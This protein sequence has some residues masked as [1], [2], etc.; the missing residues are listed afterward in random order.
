M[1]RPYFYFIA[2]AGTV[3]LTIGAF[4]LAI[5]LLNLALEDAFAGNEGSTTTVIATTPSP[6]QKHIATVY[7][8]MG[9]GA[10]GW[11]SMKVNVRKSEEQ[12]SSPGDVF[13]ASC[14]TEVQAQWESN[15]TLRI[16]YSSHDDIVSSHQERLSADKIVRVLY[17]GK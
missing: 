14:G 17:L 13:S 16:L 7:S 8:N 1:R 3:V 12:F 6:D 4:F 2:G 10:A 11:C 9:G 5:F 15:E